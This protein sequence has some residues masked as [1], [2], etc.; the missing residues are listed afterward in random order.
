MNNK[1]SEIKAQ[2]FAFP[3][4]YGV[5]ELKTQ[6]KALSELFDQQIYTIKLV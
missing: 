6:G 3:N 1:I 2:I 5:T 4:R